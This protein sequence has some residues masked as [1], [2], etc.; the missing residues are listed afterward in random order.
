MYK[1][2]TNITDKTMIDFT[3]CHQIWKNESVKLPLVS[4]SLTWLYIL[5]ALVACSI[6]IKVLIVSL[7][8]LFSWAKKYNS[9]WL[10]GPGME[11]RFSRRIS[12]TLSYFPW[13]TQVK[14]GKH[15][16]FKSNFWKTGTESDSI[17][18][19]LWEKFKTMKLFMSLAT[20][21]LAQVADSLLDGLYFV[22]LKTNP[23]L[24]HVPAWVHGVQGTLLFTCKRRKII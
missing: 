12:G 10:A 21:L 20:T 5:I 8:A 7:W 1:L 22:K 13:D 23:R 3:K 2:A 15:L 11:I 9:K 6:N 19:K 24:V 17:F 18:R 4:S 14:T 16:I